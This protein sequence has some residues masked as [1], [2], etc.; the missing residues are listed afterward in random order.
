MTEIP[1]GGGRGGWGG[2]SVGKVSC[3][4]HGTPLRKT[5]VGMKAGAE[6]V[7]AQ[8]CTPRLT[9]L[10]LFGWRAI[11]GPPEAVPETMPLALED[12]AFQ[13]TQFT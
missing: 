12:T 8:R 13:L 11:Q 2:G 9:S 3:S 6:L 1:A 7:V 10:A 4:W 5:E